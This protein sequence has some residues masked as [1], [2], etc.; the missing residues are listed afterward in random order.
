MIKF[1]L[2][3]RELLIAFL[4]IFICGN[5][6][7]PLCYG[8]LLLVLVFWTIRNMHEHLIIL[9]LLI[10]ILGDSRSHSFA[11]VKNLRIIIVTYLAVITI[12]KLLKKKYPLHPAFLLSIPF[13]I[14]ASISGF[15][16]P[17]PLISYS[18]LISYFFLLL[19]VFH[20]I[21]YHIRQKGEQLLMDILYLAAWVFLLGLLMI[22]VYPSF[23]FL[24]SRYRGLFG[25]P[26]G[27]G[28][29]CSLILPYLMI[30]WKI[31][32]HQRKNIIWA[33][34]LLI[35]SILLS[36]SRTALGAI[37]LFLFL[38]KLYRGYPIR[39]WLFILAILPLA[40]LFF[41]FISLEQII[42]AI[43]LA[44]YLRV[45][46]LTT[47]TGR[48]FA[49]R[50]IWD[51]LIERIWLGG[52]FAYEEFIFDQFTAFFLS[53]EHQGRMHNSYLTLIMNTGLIG[54]SLLLGFL[55]LIL[56]RMKPAYLAI[57]FLVVALL[58]AGFE[59]WLSSSLNAFSIHF[60]MIV[61]ILNNYTFLKQKHLN[62]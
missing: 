29:Y 6:F 16:S 10:L 24:A 50:I 49:W 8:I 58:S 1:L 51:F 4:I 43:G 34:V 35:I 33:I 19:I 3:Y 41:Q 23:V 31:Y 55:I 46:S 7:L 15:R 9:L 17:I 40:I 30:L 18:K 27:L 28:I 62:Q 60:Y 42:R 21:Q 22:V 5:L 54:F 11:F 61:V 36:E 52:G 53:T 38:Y 14:S 45:E 59:S 44:E 20:Y 37:I 2:T 57:P 32:P 39:R 26:N 48:Y 56:A 13:F 12:W 47:G 25:N